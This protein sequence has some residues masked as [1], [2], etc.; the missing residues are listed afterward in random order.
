MEKILMIDDDVQLTELV[1]EFLSSQKYEFISKHFP[2]EGL[3]YL[4]KN[5]ADIIINRSS[6]VSY[7]LN[8][9]I[10]EVIVLPSPYIAIKTGFFASAIAVLIKTPS[11]PNSIAMVASEA[12]PSPASTITGTVDCSLINFIFILF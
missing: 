1:N 9:A 11:Q 12:V 6:S 10:R 5:G 2:E 4:N 8:A 7:S 3:E